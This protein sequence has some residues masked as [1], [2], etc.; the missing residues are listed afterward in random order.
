MQ[1]SIR[2][3]LAATV[4]A[5]SAF[6]ASPAFAQDETDPP[7][8]FTITGN[9]AI[10]TDYRF[11]GLSLSAGDPAIQGGINVN[12]SSGFYVGTWASSLQQDG[13]DVY[14]SMEV[15]LFAGWTGEVTPGLTADLGL[16]YY[17]YP[18]G[19]GV[20]V[21]SG[22]SGDYFEPYASLSTA[23]GPATAKVGV[24][25]AWKQEALDFNADGVGD[26]NLYVYTDLGIGVPNTPISLSAHLGYADGAQSP[27]FLT[28]QSASYDGGFDYS[29][30]A[31]ANITKNLSVGVTYLGVEG[32]S[33]DGFS[34]DA[35]VGTLKVSF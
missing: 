2:G 27:K 15:D 4:L 24:A 35:V 13:A 10:V 16:V 23:F 33:I 1:T 5:G 29:V 18:A 34:D 28:G 20:L 21:P 14:G 22:A 12:H 26:D 19:D 30:G 6:M 32:N 3:L 9:A 8:D 11:R 7:S 25:Y 31:T 17:A